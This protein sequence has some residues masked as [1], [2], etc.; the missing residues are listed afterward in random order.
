M[1]VRKLEEQRP[2]T[3]ESEQLPYPRVSG[4]LRPRQPQDLGSLES[5]PNSIE[6]R[7][8]CL[9]PDFVDIPPDGLQVRK[10]PLN[11]P[12]G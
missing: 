2:T 1:A 11:K 6:G 10:D 7:P 5:I 3:F 8:C 9:E 12:I 4:V